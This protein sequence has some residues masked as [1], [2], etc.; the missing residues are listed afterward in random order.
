MLNLYDILFVK[1]GKGKNSKSQGGGNRKKNLG[2]IYRPDEQA[3]HL[4]P[5]SRVPESPLATGCRRNAS[6]ASQQT[7]QV[8]LTLRTPHPEWGPGVP[9]TQEHQARA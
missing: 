7:N 6:L 2:R 4:D 1:T 3:S 5:G 9:E 8:C